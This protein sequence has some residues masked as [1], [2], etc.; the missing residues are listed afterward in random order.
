MRPEPAKQVQEVLDDRFV[1]N[2]TGQLC[3]RKAVSHMDMNM[4]VLVSREAGMPE[5]T[6]VNQARRDSE[7]LSNPVF[8]V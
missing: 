8:L 2:K 4:E 6:V 3:C 7:V 5:A 1:W